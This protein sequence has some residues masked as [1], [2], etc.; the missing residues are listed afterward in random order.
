MLLAS[1]LIARR[2][3]AIAARAIGER[4]VKQHDHGSDRDIRDCLHHPIS[5]IPH[6]HSL[7]AEATLHYQ[8]RR[9]NSN[10]R[11]P[12]HK[13]NLLRSSRVTDRVK[14]YFVILAAC[15]S[16]QSAPQLH[17]SVS[18]A[19]A[20]NT[21]HRDSTK[22]ADRG[23]ANEATAKLGDASVTARVNTIHI[24]AS[25]DGGAASDAPTHARVDQTVTLYAVIRAGDTF[26]SDAP[27]P[28]LAGKPLVVQ[29][30]ASGPVIDLAWSRIEPTSANLSNTS[31]GTFRFE[32]IEY[33]ATAIDRSA[34][35]PSI[36]AD[37]RPTLLTDHGNG[38][39]TMR[40]QLAVTQDGKT[41]TTPGIDAR[42]GRGSGGLTDAVMRVTIRRDDT[43]LG[44]LTEMYGQPY[45]WASAGTSDKTHQ[46]ERL[47]GSDCADLMVYGARRMGKHISYTWTGGLPAIT[48]LLA[49]GTRGD[50]G[51]Y[52]DGAGK[53]LPFTQAGDLVLFP[54]HVGALAVD[55]GTLGVLD[56][57]DLMLHTLFDTPKEQPIKDSGYAQYAVE[58]R[59]FR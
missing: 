24:V 33:R 21:L 32:P 38:V 34:N 28:K 55:K 2:R 10:F 53:P 11:L 4:D 1:A 56:D 48:K 57:H 52:R 30:I 46:S 49:S 35:Q 29:P 3:L 40:Y 15:S 54:R 23:D 37:V 43:Y 9:D 7:D 16:A 47:E 39:G 22:S 31:S 50:D 14:K 26:Y 45:V 13:R 5:Q 44:F 12:T 58:L 19:H 36:A 25:I 41:F 59:R 27:S 6:V 20:P 51:I 18:T 8:L 17:S 42:R